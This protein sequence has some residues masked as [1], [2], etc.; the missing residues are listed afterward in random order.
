[1]VK[2]MS[3]ISFLLI[4]TVLVIVALKMSGN[5]ELVE[6][7]SST[8]VDKL[9]LINVNQSKDSFAKEA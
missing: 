1:M 6:K 3:M 2:L 5:G 9:G 7:T 4:I 8:L